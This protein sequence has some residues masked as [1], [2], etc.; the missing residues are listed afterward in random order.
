MQPIKL[1]HAWPGPATAA[2]VAA[3]GVA[4]FVRLGYGVPAASALVVA[5]FAGGAVDVPVYRGRGGGP[6]GAVDAPR[7]LGVNLG[8][9]VV[10]LG[11]AVE[12]GASLPSAA[13]GAVTAATAAVMALSLCLARAVPGRGLML[14]WPLTGLLGAALA[15]ALTPPGAS[16]TV[17]AFIAGLAGPL[18]GA[19][20]PYLPMI[21]RVGAVRVGIGGGGPFDGLVWSG[22]LAALL[23]APA[24]PGYHGG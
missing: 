9:C 12:R 18:L 2:V 20:L 8:G 4:A 23:G 17:V 21:F 10:P 5:V 3:A 1:A 11:V 16:P 14:A 6:G 13:A 24:A 15:L 22:L 7:R 19:E